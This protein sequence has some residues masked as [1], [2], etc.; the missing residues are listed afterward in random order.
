MMLAW[1]RSEWERKAGGTV[2]AEEDSMGQGR[3]S[4]YKLREKNNMSNRAD[5]NYVMRTP[6]G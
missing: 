6:R 5:T 1:G 2:S 4:R 3:E